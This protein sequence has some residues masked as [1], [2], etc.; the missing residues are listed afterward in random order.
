MH[1]PFLGASELIE[2][3]VQF[4]W[5]R[6]FS[7]AVLNADIMQADT[8]MFWWKV[9]M[10]LLLL[11][12]ALSAPLLASES[13]TMHTLLLCLECVF[14][15]L[16]FVMTFAL[17]FAT[18]MKSKD[19]SLSVEIINFCIPLVLLGWRLRKTHALMVHSVVFVPSPMPIGGVA[20]QYTT[21]QDLHWSRGFAR[22]RT[23]SNK[24]QPMKVPTTVFPDVEILSGEYIGASMTQDAA[25]TP[26]KSSQTQN[27]TPTP[28]DGFEPSLRTSEEKSLAPIAAPSAQTTARPRGKRKPM[29]YVVLFLA[30][31]EL[32]MGFSFAV[33]FAASPAPDISAIG[34]GRSNNDRPPPPSLRGRPPPPPENGNATVNNSTDTLA[35]TS[36]GL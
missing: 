26:S 16:Y 12:C 5:L 3:I 15:L 35:N 19:A 11:N 24:V 31:S 32:I 27:A 25:P 2:L 4:S 22:T 23:R 10:W 29:R 33:V 18:G 34:Y 28:S 13:L 30:A 17:V 36:T 9:M 8:A 14:D 21:A 7:G 20:V 1:I 6:N